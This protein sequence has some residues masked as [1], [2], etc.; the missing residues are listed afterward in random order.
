[1]LVVG[2]LLLLPR[3]AKVIPG[4]GCGSVSRLAVLT[5]LL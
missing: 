3:Y 1:M 4:F 2:M 5:T